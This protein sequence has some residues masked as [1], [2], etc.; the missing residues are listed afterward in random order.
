LEPQAWHELDLLRQRREAL[1]LTAPKP[2]P[3]QALLRKG[4]LIGGSCVL[5][6]AAVWGGVQFLLA[7][8]QQRINALQ[9]AAGEHAALTQRVQAERANEAK[10]KQSNQTIADGI[11]GV[12]SGSALMVALAHITPPSIQLTKVTQ[13]G[14]SLAIKG[15]AAQP[16]GLR[17]VN[18]FQLELENTPFFQPRGAKLVK[19]TVE[20]TPAQQGQS[21]SSPSQR[22]N[23]DLTAAFA[24]E[25][26]KEMRPLLVKLGALGL[27]RRHQ[28]L[29]QDGLL[30]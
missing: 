5:A 15:V 21:V 10:L 3:A 24:A 16:L 14:G 22:L 8:L 27:A 28:L 12:R 9:P 17:S 19:A 18:A 11:I 7:G 26:A 23:F 29:R 13:Q 20:Q 2:V 4:G 6:V 25:A 30:P 1:G